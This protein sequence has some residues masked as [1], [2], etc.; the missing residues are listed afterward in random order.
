[1]MFL[2][3]RLGTACKDENFRRF[4]SVAFNYLENSGAGKKR[5]CFPL[6]RPFAD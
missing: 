3:Q 6:E 2:E 5:V 4:R 1:M